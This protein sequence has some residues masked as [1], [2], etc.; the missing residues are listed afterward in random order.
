MKNKKVAITLGIMCII[1][2]YAI[3]VQLN[4]ISNAVNT[5]GKTE[6]ENKLRD[7]VLRAKE[8]YDRK[9]AELEELDKKL[10]EVRS[11]STTN[12]SQSQENQEEL[13]KINTYLGLTDVVGEGITITVKDN[14]EGSMITAN[15]DIIHDSDLRSIVNELKNSGAEAISING[16]RIVQTSAITCVG[17]V[18]QINGEKVGSPFEIKAIGNQAVLLGVDRPGSY[19]Y[20]M[21]ENS[22]IP[23]EIKKS[24]SVEIPKYNSVLT[25]KFVK[26]Q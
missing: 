26:P 3:C 4:T 1:L 8:E 17:S 12:N 21:K 10:E 13:K 24:N 19:L 23:Y 20:Y 14:A 2:V 22:R 11:E 25:T 9:Y 7:Q 5:V 6:T 16:Q 15:N 18:I